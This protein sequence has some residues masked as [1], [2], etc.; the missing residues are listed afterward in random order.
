MRVPTCLDSRWRHPLA[1]AVSTRSMVSELQIPGKRLKRRLLKQVEEETTGTLSR[2]APRS[3]SVI[4]R[5]LVS[6]D[7]APSQTWIEE[8]DEAVWNSP[9]ATDPESLCQILAS[10]FIFRSETTDEEGLRQR[11]W[12]VA[13]KAYLKLIQS[14]DLFDSYG[15]LSVLLHT[16][17]KD[18]VDPSVFDEQEFLNAIGY[19][20]GA[21]L[22]NMEDL[23]AREAIRT[24]LCR[25]GALFDILG[26]RQSEFCA[27]ITQ[28]L[29][30]HESM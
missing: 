1:R 27:Y 9:S 24:S 10:L 28:S 16:L 26:D 11:R 6:M 30:E 14:P 20:M 7:Y 8:L 18:T 2:L 3:L 19:R 17:N 29:D 15:Q 4:I 12:S 22:A 5:A 25:S 23:E 13:T 21:S